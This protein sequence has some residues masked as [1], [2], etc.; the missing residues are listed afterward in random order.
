MDYNQLIIQY[1]WTALIAVGALAGVVVFLVARKKKKSSAKPILN[2]TEYFDALGGESNYISSERE[3]SRI[4]VYLHD[5]SKIDKEKI[6]EAGVAGFIEKSD[7][8]TLVVKDNAEEVYEKIF[9]A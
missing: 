4:V 5:Y 7:K 6:K 9:K 1:W 2:R 3:G 8:L